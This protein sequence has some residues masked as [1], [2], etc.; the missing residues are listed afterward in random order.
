VNGDLFTVG[1]GRFARVFLGVAEG[2]RGPIDLDVESVRDH[3][4]EAMDLT[5]Y[6]VPERTRDE[7]ELFTREIDWAT[8]DE[9]TRAMD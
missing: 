6:H 2:Y 7:C 9:I 8:F 1:G 5:G 4:D 3:F